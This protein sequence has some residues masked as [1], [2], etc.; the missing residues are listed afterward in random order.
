M[1]QHICLYDMPG[2]EMTGAG[3]AAVASPTLQQIT[4]VLDG[5]VGANYNV[6][7]FIIHPAPYC[8]LKHVSI[9]FE[10]TLFSNNVHATKASE[11]KNGYYFRPFCFDIS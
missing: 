8:N 7:R 11:T 6:S 4:A 3:A 1:G 2:L 10:L 5:H 9:V